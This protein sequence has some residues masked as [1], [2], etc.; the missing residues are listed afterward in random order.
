MRIVFVEARNRPSRK[1]TIAGRKG[2]SLFSMKNHHHN[3]PIQ[4]NSKSLIHEAIAT[5]AYEL[6]E[7]KGR[8]ENQAEALWVEAERALVAERRES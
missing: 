8:P 4:H 3:N 6:W 7:K 5:R 2:I 1:D